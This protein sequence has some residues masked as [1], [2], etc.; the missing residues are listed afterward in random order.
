MTE[1][2]GLLQAPV[3][4]RRIFHRRPNAYLHFLVGVSLYA[5]LLSTIS[6]LGKP[7]EMI[8][9]GPVVLIGQVL[10]IPFA[11]LIVSY[12]VIPKFMPQRV[13]SAYELL[14]LRLGMT[15]RMLGAILLASIRVKL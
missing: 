5:S 8:N 2:I 13:T 12:W 1:D 9:K 11:F 14:E 4:Q 6:Y 15:G 3:E 7:G 10:S